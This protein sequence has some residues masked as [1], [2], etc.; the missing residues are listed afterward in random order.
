M[1]EDR[2]G[3]IDFKEFLSV[4]EKQKSE[5]ATQNDETSTVEAFVALGG[6][7]CV[8]VLPLSTF[9]RRLWENGLQSSSP[10]FLNI[11]LGLQADK[12]GV[13]SVERL[14]NTIKVSCAPR[15]VTLVTCSRGV[16]A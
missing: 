5:E 3:T 6:K 15:T 12:S 4:I 10:R 11:S 7:V 9:D 8:R 13:I 16:Y 2:S 1:D 14:M